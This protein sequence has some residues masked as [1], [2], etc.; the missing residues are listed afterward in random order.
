[1]RPNSALSTDAFSSLPL[2]FQ[3]LAMMCLLLVPLEAQADLIQD[4][5]DR[6]ARYRVIQT[7][8]KDYAKSL[9]LQGKSAREAWTELSTR[10]FKCAVKDVYLTAKESD[11]MILCDKEPTDIENC[12]SLF[13]TVSLQ[14]TDPKRPVN[15]LVDTQPD[16][17][18]KYV[19]ATCGV[20]DPSPKPR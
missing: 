13:V 3:R 10:G 2:A 16:S 8:A 12:L 1:M 14:W 20:S 17:P 11:P 18:I 4:Y 9:G 7:A 19:T 5:T 15:E 6:I